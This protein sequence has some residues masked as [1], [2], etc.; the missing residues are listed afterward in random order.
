M[1]NEVGIQELNIQPQAGVIGV[2]SRLNYKAWY[3]IAEFV[4][5]STQSFYSHQQELSIHGINDVDIS[6]NYDS[7]HDVLTIT[8]TAYGME[9]DDFARAVKVDSPPEDKTGRNEFGMGLKTAASWFGN[10]WSVRSTK[11]GSNIEYYTEINIPEMREKNVNSVYIRK[12]LVHPSSHGTT[13]IIREVTKKIGSPRTKGKIVELLK[14][15]YRRD[16]NNGLVRISYDGIPLYYDEYECLSFRNRIWRKNLDFYFDFDNKEHH[17]VGFVGILANG[18]FGRAGFALF[19]RNRVVVGG[20][21]FNYKPDEI[22]GQAQSTQSHK[23]FGELDL[24][25]FPINQAKDGFVWDDGLE[26]TFVENLK[27]RIREYIDIAKMTNKDRA[28]EEETSQAVSDNVQNQVQESIN[29]TFNS[30]PKSTPSLFDTPFDDAQNDLQTDFDFYKE[31]Q[32]EQNNLPDEIDNKIRTY[33]IPLD[34][35]TK[36]KISVQWTKGGPT[37]WINVD[38]A[39]DGASANV[40]LNINHPFFKPFSEQ[41][42]FKKVLEKFAIAFALAEIR[43]KNNSN[44]DGSV[45]PSAFRNHINEYLRILSDDE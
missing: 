25:D 43:A 5:N 41:E 39:E 22:F 26:E 42:D 28:K 45:S 35:A 1:N 38:P 21:E 27:I 15:M 19:R 23:L 32:A 7:E 4:D 2:F 33:N 11:L 36:C 8:D 12:S 31:Y 20:E 44:E 3:A 40:Q 34:R 14:S 10:I 37:T 18:G 6:I 17:V 29:H 9:F 13:I 30:P 24:D 16:L